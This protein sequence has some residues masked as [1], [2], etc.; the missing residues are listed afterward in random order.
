MKILLVDADSKDG[1]P[2]L[3]LMKISSYYKQKGD[4]IILFKGIPNSQFLE[5]Y[6]R[7]YISC[8][9]FQNREKVIQGARFF[10]N[11]FVGGSGIDLSNTLDNYVEHLIPDYSLY[12][13]DFS[14]GFTSRGCIRNCPWCV[15]PGKEGYIRNHADIR[16]FHNLEHKKIILLD[17]NI[18]AA[19]NYKDTFQYLIDNKLKVNINSGFDIRLITPENAELIRQTK[20]R[21]WRFKGTKYTFAYD[22]PQYKNAVQKGIAILR[23]AGIKLARDNC[24]FYVLVGYNT[25]PEQD[26]ERIH[27]LISNNVGPY[28]MRYNQTVGPNRILLHLS[29]WV[30]RKLYQFMDFSEYDYSDSQK[31]YQEYFKG[32]CPQRIWSKSK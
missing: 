11:S 12:D 16:E 29:R 4:T 20:I 22:Q 3:A 28:I 24:I 10:S 7:V 30:N 18:L 25:T 13:I 19:P 23:N 31:C 17:N 27:F 26:L 8:I 9:F 14:L 6:D 32:N 15:V 1:F 5:S 21:D 2:N